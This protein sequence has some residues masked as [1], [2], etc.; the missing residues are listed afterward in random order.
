MSVFQVGI[1]FSV[2]CRFFKSVRYF[3]LLSVFKIS[4]YRF[5][6]F[7]ISLCAKAPRADPKILLP[8]Q[9][10]DFD[11]YPYPQGRTEGM[12]QWYFSS[13]NHF[14]FSFYIAFRQSFRFLYSFCFSKQINFSFYVI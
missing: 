5:G 13:R 9:F 3:T 6:I 4:R 12:G 10:T 11:G 14:S 2:Y 8:S 1:G 7:G